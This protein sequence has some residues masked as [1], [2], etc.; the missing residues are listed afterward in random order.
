[1]I[2]EYIILYAIADFIA[3]HLIVSEILEEKQG[4][5]ILKNKTKI[6]KADRMLIDDLFKII[7]IFKKDLNETSFSLIKDKYNKIYKSVTQGNVVTYY[8]VFVAL[9]LLSLYTKTPLQNRKFKIH[10]NRVTKIQQLLLKNGIN[11][12][13]EKVKI[14]ED[15][16]LNSLNFARKIYKALGGEI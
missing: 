11:E 12:K 14:L 10:K 5:L 2:N 8:P 1:M 6:D 9:E 3:R 4:E 7:N 16:T 15:T 13:G